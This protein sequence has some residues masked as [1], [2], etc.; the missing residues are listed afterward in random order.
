MKVSAI[1][2]DGK[3]PNLALM[4]LAAWHRARGDHV[5]LEIDGTVDKAYI[6]VI[7]PQNRAR[8]L[9]IAKFFPNSEVEIGGSGFNYS[10]TLPDDIEHT[11][12][13]YDLWNIDYSMGFTSRGCIRNCGFCIVPRKEGRIRA[14]SPLEEFIHPDHDK[15]VLFDNNLLAAPNWRETLAGLIENGYKVDINQGL[16]IRLVNEDNASM[17]ADLRY[18]NSRWKYRTLRFA[19]DSMDVEEDVRRGVRVLNDAGVQF[20]HLVFYMLVGFNTTFEEDMARYRVL[21]ED[22]GVYPFV[23]VYNRSTHSSPRLKAF[24]RWI[25]RRIHKVS[26]WEDY[27]RNPDRVVVT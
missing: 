24:G 26:S 13:A 6:S 20:K 23:M 8:A 1:Q 16:D 25:N 22:L 12:P 7:W 11:M 2:V 10:V 3:L 21:W 15:V 27:T 5:S 18:Y 17:L 19:F 14:H 4:K 9:G